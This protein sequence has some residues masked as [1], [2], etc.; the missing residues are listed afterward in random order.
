MVGSI[1]AMAQHLLGAKAIL[2]K[3]V[4]AQVIRIIPMQKTA[5][6]VVAE[7]KR[8]SDLGL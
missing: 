7:P 4:T 3:Q 2:R 8:R 1:R 6:R 5:I